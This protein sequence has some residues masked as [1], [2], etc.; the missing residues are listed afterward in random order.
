MERAQNNMG[1]TFPSS[2]MGP[3]FLSATFDRID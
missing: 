2:R 1:I 3:A